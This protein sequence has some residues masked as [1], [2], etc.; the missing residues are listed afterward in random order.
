MYTDLH[1]TNWKHKLLKTCIINVPGDFLKKEQNIFDN[2]QKL[3]K[4]K[5][6][7]IN[8]HI[9]E[10]TIFKQVSISSPHLAIYT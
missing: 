9:Q 7:N 1:K 3:P 10:T 6:K 8:L 2:V 4:F 5:E